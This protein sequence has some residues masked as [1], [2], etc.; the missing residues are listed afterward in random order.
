MGTLILNIGQFSTRK[1]HYNEKL[2]KYAENIE[3]LCQ[4]GYGDLAEDTTNSAG[5]YPEIIILRNGSYGSSSEYSCVLENRSVMKLCR[6]P[7]VQFQ[8]KFVNRRPKKII[9]RIRSFKPRE[10]E[11]PSSASNVARSTI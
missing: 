8:L 7:F 2:Q 5:F 3:Y 9:Q 11:S 4:L 6:N 10:E 1:R